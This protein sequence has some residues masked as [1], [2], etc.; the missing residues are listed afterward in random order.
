M[1][2]IDDYSKVKVY[3]WYLRSLLCLA[4]KQRDHLRLQSLKYIVE[5]ANKYFL[6]SSSTIDRISDVEDLLFTWV[7]LIVTPRLRENLPECFEQIQEQQQSGE[8]YNKKFIWLRFNLLESIVFIFYEMGSYFDE[9]SDD[10]DE[11]NIDPVTVY[12]L[13]K[14]DYVDIPFLKLDGTST[15]TDDYNIVPVQKTH[16]QGVLEILISMVSVPLIDR[17]PSRGFHDAALQK[18]IVIFKL[19]SDLFAL[20]KND[21]AYVYISTEEK[22]YIEKRH[23]LCCEQMKNVFH[24][25]LQLSTD[26]KW[27][28]KANM[29]Y[30]YYFLFGY[31]DEAMDVMKT[32][33]KEYNTDMQKRD[34]YALSII[35]SDDAANK[36]PIL[37]YLFKKLNKTDVGIPIFVLAYYTLFQSYR[38][39]N[40][41]DNS[42]EY[43]EQFQHICTSLNIDSREDYDKTIV[44]LLLATAFFCLGL[45]DKALNLIKQL[46]ETVTDLAD[47]L[48]S[49]CG[50]KCFLCLIDVQHIMDHGLTLEL[51]YVLSECGDPNETIHV[52]PQQIKQKLSLL[53]IRHGYD[54]YKMRS[55]RIHELTILDEL[56]K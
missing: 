48:L 55:W 51:P 49:M 2:L 21:P 11:G 18:S 52:K 27:K 8:F 15:N 40:Q 41:W 16:L 56:K 37:S 7:N 3:T 24:A 29:S 44:I 28:I 43:I 9:E 23:D 14:D 38:M 35:E 10:E 22:I 25:A 26:Q 54:C 5:L 30:V 13:F 31:Y 39:T 1:S 45:L 12:S 53:I 50:I 4:L 33:I 42:Q 19:K 32:V 17:P 20:E 47:E 6:S 34:Y 46:P 36:C